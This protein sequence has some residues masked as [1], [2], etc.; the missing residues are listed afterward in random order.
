MSPESS[1]RSKNPFALSFL[2]QLQEE[3]TE[4]PLRQ[5]LDEAPRLEERKSP[6]KPRQ[7]EKREEKE[8]A[9]KEG[10]E[11]F[12]TDRH[13]QEPKGKEEIS[14]LRSAPN[15]PEKTRISSTFFY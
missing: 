8:R 5:H 1:F 4:A 10:A 3:I 11:T 2:Y 14:N 15:N 7:K 13:Q 9:K 6:E 12:E